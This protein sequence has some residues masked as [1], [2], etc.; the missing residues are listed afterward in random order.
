MSFLSAV[1]N[2]QH[3]ASEC[4]NSITAGCLQNIYNTAWN[5]RYIQ[6]CDAIADHN[7]A[8]ANIMA[9]KIVAESANSE[10]KLCSPNLRVLC[11]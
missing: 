11:K 6:N 7:I 1:L 5:E 10:T 9:L 3:I 4:R 8:L 2:K